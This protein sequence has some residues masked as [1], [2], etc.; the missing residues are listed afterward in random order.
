MDGTE[1]HPGSTRSRP[2]I[3]GLTMAG[4]AAAAAV[5]SYLD[6]LYLVHRAGAHGH[7]AYLYPL[8]PDGLI[9]ISAQS[10]YGA[11][12]GGQPRPRW[13]TTGIV[14]G[15]VL[16]AAMNVAAGAGLK[17]PLALV[18]GVV[19]VVFFVALE[20]LIGLI[21][22]GRAGVGFAP[23]R[24]PGPA[25]QSHCGHTVALTVGEAVRLADEHARQCL[26]EPI[27]QRQLAASFG[28][29]RPKVAELVGATP[30]TRPGRSVDV[31]RPGR[32]DAPAPGPGLSGAG[33]NGDHPDGG[34]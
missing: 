8:L 3:A 1:D 32:P 13:A 33:A 19:P 10:L 4:I 6:G 18:D 29:S 20:I 25:A 16:T 27:S 7:A 28:L 31:P 26:G 9:V 22:R 24:A 14:L 34:R 2:W 21:R 5:I 15:A 11:A 17:V 23:P 30:Q 12:Q